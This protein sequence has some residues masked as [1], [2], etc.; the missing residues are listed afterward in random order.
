MSVLPKKLIDRLNN[1]TE[2]GGYDFGT[3]LQECFSSIAVQPPAGSCLF[4]PNYA[5]SA[6]AEA[7]CGQMAGTVY[8][9]STLNV[10][11]FYDG[12]TWQAIDP[13]TWNLQIATN[14]VN[15]LAAQSAATS[16]QIALTALTND[17]TAHNHDGIN[18]QP[19]LVKDLIST[20]DPAGAF[21]F[22]DGAGGVD[23]AAIASSLV[24]QLGGVDI[25][26]AAG[27]INF[28]SAC[29]SAIESAPGEVLI[30]MPAVQS[31]KVDVAN[32]AAA[33]LANTT[34]IAST[35]ASIGVLQTQVNNNE[36]DF[37]AH[38]HNGTDSQQIQAGNLLSQNGIGT[39]IPNNGVL[40]ADGAG[41][42]TFIDKT[43]LGGGLVNH[44]HNGTDADRIKAGNTE[45]KDAAG[46]NY[47]NDFILCADGA[48]GWT[49]TD[50]NTIGGGADNLTDTHFLA[51]SE[52]GNFSSSALDFSGLTVGKWYEVKFNLDYRQGTS[53]AQNYSTDFFALHNGVI[54]LR[55]RVVESTQTGHSIR[56]TPKGSLKFQATATT[57]T[58]VWTR[59]GSVILDGNG[60]T[61]QTFTQLT[62]L[63]DHAAGS[64]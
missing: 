28:N 30:D 59:I 8:Y 31:L 61:G 19:I 51:S 52:S 36:A 54:I 5:S 16:I 56:N 18:S 1:Q 24:V 60:T 41:G 63:N 27:T 57:L 42:W 49:P 64:F 33:I 11:E 6:A 13:A 17:F 21:Y 2:L 23:C 48:G 26:T 45:S 58:W 29:F 32:N 44:E 15:A 38:T 14:S 4:V 55:N 7:T 39:N 3:I 22:S 20:G 12:T 46:V 50:K 37:N 10:L 62:E 53:T 43:T 34:A 35:N 9:N 25:S 40:C 47:A